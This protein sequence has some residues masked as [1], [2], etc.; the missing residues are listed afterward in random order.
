MGWL[1]VGIA[2]VVLYRRISTLESKVRNLE[3]QSRERS[4]FT[5]PPAE[6]AESAA[7][8]DKHQA[9]ST[10]TPAAPVQPEV[11]ST[12]WQAS[13]TTAPFEP[14]A[15]PQAEEAAAAAPAA[16]EVLQPPASDS[17][18][19]SGSRGPT[20]AGLLNRGLNLVVRYFTEGNL[21][22]RI[23]IL[24]L[25]FGFGFLAKYAA[26]RT[27]I[28]LSLRLWGIGISGIVLI[29]L[30]WY[31]RQ[32]RRTYALALQ[33]GGLG[34]VYLTLYVSLRLF[35]AISPTVALL[36]MVLLVIAGCLFSLLQNAQV[37]AVLALT[38]GFLAPVLASTG[39]GSHIVLFSYYLILNAGI[40]GMAWFRAWRLLNLLGFGFTFVIGL[41]WG[42][43]QYQPEFYLS[44]QLFLMA[45][46]VLYTLVAILFALRQPPRLRG[47]VDGGLVFG[48][49][50][51]GF[52]IQVAL[53]ESLPH[54]V[55]WSAA[56]VSL[57]YGA[58]ALT[59]YIRDKR[60]ALHNLMRVFAGLAVTFATITVPLALGERWTSAIW[61]VEALGLVW[62]GTRQQQKLS[63]LAGLLLFGG[64][65]IAMGVEINDAPQTGSLFLNMT[66]AGGLLIAVTGIVAARILDLAYR[67]E[68]GFLKD[69]GLILLIY[70]ALWFAG[71]G[72]Y[73]I[74][75]FVASDQ[76]WACYLIYGALVSMCLSFWQQRIAWSKLEGLPLITVLAMLLAARAALGEV[77]HPFAGLGM[78]AW[79]LGAGVFFW[80]I[81]V[82]QRRAWSQE[83]CAPLPLVVGW[84][85]VLLLTLELNWL[86]NRVTESTAWPALSL[87]LVPSLALIMILSR[88]VW[89]FNQAAK[90]DIGTFC[91][92]IVA[93]L[94][95]WFIYINGAPPDDT[96][97]GYLPVLNPFDIASLL[98]L[99][100]MYH[101]LQ[102]AKLL[103]GMFDISTRGEGALLASFGFFWFNF[104][105]YRVLHSWLDVHWSLHA[106]FSSASV[107]ATFSIAWTLL[108]LLS[109]LYAARTAQRPV[110]LAGAALIAVVVLK[111]FAIDLASADTLARVVSFLGVG[112]LLLLVGYF[113]PMPDRQSAA[114]AADLSRE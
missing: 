106:F 66:F 68:R 76:Q 67:D 70:S 37:L 38:G 51:V 21:I 31:L 59:I 32:R 69:T 43:L 10:A 64:A 42:V 20:P 82:W 36:L 89:P 104:S 57:F 79:P 86:V 75:R 101:W 77:D 62:L 2:L 4:A 110:W 15:L 65:G 92:P 72:F 16:D 22:V 39:D 93:A 94:A 46:F 63:T 56:I 23:G 100:L 54:G 109:A 112:G 11:T 88:W 13:S 5:P 96:G 41:G 90:R 91:L 48:V 95:G 87:A 78:L 24:V 45:F 18:S 74:Y 85:Y 103:G 58:L 30:G 80:Q 49:P 35:E 26:E 14:A 55:A 102:Q 17:T 113:A 7:T 12:P 6:A 19:S 29:G 27:H 9:E 53:I 50:L 83:F 61:S 33:G 114:D 73:Q 99:Y 34:V 81:F 108:G 28:P 84:L 40:V 71:A 1:L 97:V 60:R 47:L 98:V 8:P 111:L 52:S 44:A 107:Q 105:L 25:L 3:K